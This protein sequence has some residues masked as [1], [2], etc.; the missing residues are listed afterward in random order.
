MKGYSLKKHDEVCLFYAA[1]TGQGSVIGTCEYGCEQWVP[2]VVGKF[3]G[4]CRTIRNS[5][6]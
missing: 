1:D 3:V 4:H 2:Y 5:S 6:P